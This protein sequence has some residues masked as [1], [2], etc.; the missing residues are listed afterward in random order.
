MVGQPYNPDNCAFLSSQSLNANQFNTNVPYSTNNTTHLIL[1][2]FVEKKILWVNSQTNLIESEI[3]G[4]SLPNNTGNLVINDDGNPQSTLVREY[5]DGNVVINPLVEI[6]NN[7][8][9]TLIGSVFIPANTFKVGD[10]VRRGIVTISYGAQISG[11]KGDFNIYANTTNSL[12]GATLI[13]TLSTAIGTTNYDLVS[14]GYNAA[15]PDQL[16]FSK[17]ISTTNLVGGTLNFGT[18]PATYDTNYTTFD[19]TQDAY[20]LVTINLVDISDRF[21]LKSLYLNKV[22]KPLN[23][24]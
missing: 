9:E 24:I 10:V 5:Y 3:G 7:T 11:T 21:A 18:N 19:I 23:L 13:N 16:D 8:S 6:N 20:V 12:L 2:D 1:W 17:F 22:I 4:S 14:T 15:S